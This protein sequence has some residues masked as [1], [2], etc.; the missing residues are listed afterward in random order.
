M[1]ILF[2]GWLS[3]STK[4]N[5]VLLVSFG[6]CRPSRD[7]VVGHVGA[8]TAGG[9]RKIARAHPWSYQLTCFANPPQL[10]GRR[11]TIFDHCN[12]FVRQHDLVQMAEAELQRHTP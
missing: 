8:V 5:S 3:H 9:R 11:M 2:L 4:S 7:V 10:V 1:S 12:S 6:V